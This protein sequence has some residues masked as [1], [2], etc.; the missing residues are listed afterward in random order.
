MESSLS[1]KLKKN[2]KSSFSLQ[3]LFKARKVILQLLE[4]MQYD[5]SGYIDFSINEMD[6][7]IKHSQCDM[8]L[9]RQAA[10]D[11]DGDGDAEPP[12]QAYVIFHNVNESATA[13]AS[14]RRPVIEKYIEDLF[15]IE[16]VLTKRDTLIIIIEDEPS[17]SVRK[18]LVELFNRDEIYVILHNIKRL[19]FKI[20][21]HTLVAKHR[22]LTE[23]E[24][25]EFLQKFNVT[26]LSQ[27][28]EISR[29]DPMALA[30]G[31]R[32]KQ[33]CC[34]HRKSCIALNNDY[35]RVCV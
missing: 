3:T 22:I 34:I 8:L 24:Q 12:K 19:Q 35:Y 6:A 16:Q 18:Y 14:I 30:I 27:L 29:F 23:Q 28:P 7:M 32:P 10:A 15:H 21:D 5:V 33:I 20:S 2:K 13:N 4:E 11:G 1:V 31:I 26:E 25:N 9:S 17:E